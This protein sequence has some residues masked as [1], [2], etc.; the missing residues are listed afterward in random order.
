M[1]RLDAHAC[2][3]DGGTHR[4]ARLCSLPRNTTCTAGE[5]AARG[6]LMVSSRYHAIVTSMPALVP[7]AGV[8][9]D[10]RIRNL[11]QERGHEDLL[12]TVDDPTLGDKLVDGHGTLRTEREA[13]REASAAP[14]CSNLKTHGAHGSLPGAQRARALSGISRSRAECAAGKII[15]RRSV[16]NLRR[17]V[18]DTTAVRRRW[19]RAEAGEHPNVNFLENIFDAAGAAPERV[20]LEEMRPERRVSATAR[21]IA[22]TH[23]GGARLSRRR[24]LAQGRSLRVAG[25]NSIAWVALDLA[26]M[27]EGIIVVPLYARQAPAELSP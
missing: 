10:E 1:E 5:H 26:A 27:A 8:T 18:G 6:R 14:W 25:A 17:L 12:M 3:R 22:R 16:P 13:I 24:G 2:R 20:V 11:M 7:S 21:A 23:R 9:M 15:C 4:A 19:R